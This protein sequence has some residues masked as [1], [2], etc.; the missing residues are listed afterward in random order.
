MKTMGP[1]KPLV[2]AGAWA[3]GATVLPVIEAGQS[4]TVEVGL[5]AGYRLLFILPNVLL[6]DWG[7]R[8]GDVAAGLQPW[9][10]RGTG[11][12]LRWGATGLLLLAGGLALVMAGRAVSP[13]LLL[14]DALGL[15]WMGGAVWGLDPERPF[16]RFVMDLLVAWPLVTALVA[17]GLGG[18]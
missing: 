1:G 3:L 5:L 9:T 12:G 16:D 8:G 7:D 2:V 14:V 15:V 10:E 4:V 18:A 11:R 6:A 17:W 13:R